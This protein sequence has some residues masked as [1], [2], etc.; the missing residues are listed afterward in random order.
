MSESIEQILQ[1]A[2]ER[3]AKRAALKNSREFASRLLKLHSMSLQEISQLSDLSLQDVEA[4]QKQLQ[5]SS[6]S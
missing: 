6:K 4:L 5:A 2:A 1:E 3:A